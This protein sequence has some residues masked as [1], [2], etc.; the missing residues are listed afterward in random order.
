MAGGLDLLGLQGVW[1]PALP[2]PPASLA[3]NGQSDVIVRA[4]HGESAEFLESWDE[5]DAVEIA[6][7]GYGP[8][9]ARVVVPRTAPFVHRSRSAPGG[10][11]VFLEIDATGLGVPDVWTGRIEGGQYSGDGA[12]WTAQVAGPRSW[13]EEIGVAEMGKTRECAAVLV[14]RAFEAASAPT[15]CRIDPQSGYVGVGADDTPGGGDL[16]ALATDITAKRGEEVFLVADRGAVGY[17]LYVRHPLGSPDL[18]P[19]CTLRHG[20]NCT[21]SS[22]A[23]NLKRPRAELVGVAN[24]YLAGAGLQVAS[25]AAPAG[26]RLGLRAALAAPVHSATAR[27]LTGTTLAVMSPE[28]PTIAA[29]ELELATTLRRAMAPTQAVQLADVDVALWPY[30]RP[31]YVVGASLPDPQGY[32]TRALLRIRTATF[33]VRPDLACSISG[34]LWALEGQDG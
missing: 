30:M 20:D 3:P 9:T 14:R 10:T 31:G 8:E 15:Y 18:S 11:G 26:A 12:D 33:R 29:L 22:S 21:L 17:T 6:F 7:E 4:Y 25:V 34:E 16:W 28:T 1:F 2:G 24:S 5:T 13:I 32:F 23:N 19:Y 27:A